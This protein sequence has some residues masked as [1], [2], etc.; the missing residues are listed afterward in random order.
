MHYQNNNHPTDR[1]TDTLYVL[2]QLSN[3]YL[4]ARR[5]VSFAYYNGPVRQTN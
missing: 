5:V 4:L 2:L 1:P 3:N